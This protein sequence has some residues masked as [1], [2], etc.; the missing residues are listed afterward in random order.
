MRTWTRRTMTL[1]WR[2]RRRQQQRRQRPPTE[3]R[4]TSTADDGEAWRDD[5]TDAAADRASIEGR[6]MWRRQRSSARARDSWR[7]SSD[8]C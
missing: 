1:S 3:D 2:R 5:L 6:A 4:A 8:R 7:R